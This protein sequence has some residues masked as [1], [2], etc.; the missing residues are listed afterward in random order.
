MTVY[1]SWVAVYK[2]SAVVAEAA[3]RSLA[4][5]VVVYR[6]SAEE[7]VGVYTSFEEACT[8][9]EEV[10]MYSKMCMFLVEGPVLSRTYLSLEEK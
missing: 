5:V 7:E 3:Y 9:L 4:A 6:S 10:R 8:I 1:R 2:S